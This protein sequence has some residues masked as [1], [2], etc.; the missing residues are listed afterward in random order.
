VKLP[1]FLAPLKER[2]SLLLVLLALAG[3]AAGALL[4][5]T[6]D[7]DAAALTWSAATAVVLLA[8]VV[9]IVGSL[10]H[11]DVGLDLVAALSMSA[12]IAFGEP[13]A[14]NVVALMYAGGQLLESY[15]QARARREMTALLGR[16][17]DTAIRY[18]DGRLEAVGISAITAGDRLLI[19]TGEVL[20]VDGIIAGTDAVLDQSALTGEPLP[21]R[22]AAGA[23]ALSGTTSTGPAFDLLVLRPAAESTYARIVSLIERA[24]SSKAP[25][26][27]LA[28]RYA[29]WFLGVTRGLAGA[30]WWISGDHIRALAVL[31][32]ATPCPLILAVPVALISGLSR[33]AALGVLVK[34][35]G[36]LEALAQA[37]TAILD[38]TGTLTSG[39][40]AVGT[41]A[42][43]NGW[44]RDDVLR[45]AASLD[46]ASHHVVA[47]ALVAEAAR[48]DLDL[49]PP[50]SVRETPG[51]GIQGLVGG[52]RVVVGGRSFVLSLLADAP[53]IAEKS[54]AEVLV[55][56]DGLLAGVIALTEAVR[57]DAK[58]AIQDLRN[59]GLTRLVLAS[60]DHTAQVE[61]V[62][63]E[64]GLDAAHGDLTPEQKLGI[65]AAARDNGPVMM[66]GDGVNDAPALAAADVGIALGARGSAASSEA[67]TVVVLVDA[68]APLAAARRIADR[69]MR[70]AGQSVLVGLG[71]SLA[72]MVAGATG[73]LPPL[74]GA[75]AQEAID[76]AVILNALRVLRPMED[77]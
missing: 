18:A 28:D 14:G 6:G 43:V 58:T 46:Q 75:I 8:L 13:L 7:R 16:V 4:F 66:I 64:L 25:M 52:R 40:P 38:K 20:P 26:T 55:A 69:A 19:R 15:A 21:V 12:A 1:S 34:D 77:G 33:A 71:L 35:G 51:S 10:R 23:E 57:P 5:W 62:A 74:G 73:Y 63:R 30:A 53:N 45:L 54:G 60:G 61:K 59:S 41:I 37:R 3:L 56:V 2:R 68:L 24:Q 42:T 31:V 65:V 22:I 49:E 32:A 29:L 44:S 48:R 17:A 27:R 11:G 76:V 67:A 50:Q 70:I 39:Q 9:E 36:A 72:A 47:A